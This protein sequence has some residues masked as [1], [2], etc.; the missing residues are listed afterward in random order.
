[1]IRKL[2][3]RGILTYVDGTQ[4]VGALDFD[5]ATLQPD[6]LSVDAYKWMISPNG[7]G[8]IYVRPNVREWLK[9]NVIGWRSDAG[10]RSVETLYLGAPRF[11]PS[12]E[13]YEGGM[14]AFPSLLG[15]GGSLALLEEIGSTA[16]EARV[17]TLAN[18]IREGLL[19]LGA[20]LHEPMENLLPS[21]IVLMRVPGV[22]SSGLAKQLSE[23][24]IHVSA[25]RGFL[26]VSPHL[27]NNE[28]DVDSLIRAIRSLLP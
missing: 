20:E 7:A 1:M 10:W 9:P 11:T 4:S 6:F 8:F 2:R 27:Y 25:R 18:R 24:H 21:Q 17:L 22:D 16:I 13:K 3:E 12:A 23:R 26:R 19:A 5:C 15:M 14:L 28:D